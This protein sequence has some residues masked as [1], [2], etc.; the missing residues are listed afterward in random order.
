MTSVFE[1]SEI[2]CFADIKHHS[3][4]ADIISA[5]ILLYTNFLCPTFTRIL[6]C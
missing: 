5:C 2:R 4:R 1:R 3:I 6:Y